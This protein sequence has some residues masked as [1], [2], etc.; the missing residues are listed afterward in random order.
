MGNKPL[1]V[2][3]RSPAYGTQR[4]THS[5]QFADK[6]VDRN[7]EHAKRFESQLHFASNGKISVKRN[8][9]ERGFIGHAETNRNSND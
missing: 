9:L 3:H 4:S 1:L 7:I 2:A 5:P 6:S 8:T